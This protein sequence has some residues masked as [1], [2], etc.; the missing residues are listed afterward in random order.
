[1]IIVLASQIS[2][3]S[4]ILYAS[5]LHLNYTVRAHGGTECAGDAL[6]LILHHGRGIA[7][8]VDLAGVDGKAA[9]GAGIDAEAA[10]L[11]QIGVECNFC[12]KI[13]SL[14]FC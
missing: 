13:S 9:L 3:F 2:P 14:G 1:M 4:T 7:F 10:A 12:H 11:A 8:L 5:L 6:F